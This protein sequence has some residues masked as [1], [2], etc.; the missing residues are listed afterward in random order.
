[1]IYAVRIRY[2][3]V[4]FIQLLSRKTILQ[5]EELE[6]KIFGPKQI[7][8]AAN[9]VQQ[10]TFTGSREDEQQGNETFNSGHNTTVRTQ[11][12]EEFEETAL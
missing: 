11:Q 8:V 2:F 3:R 5:A 12:D 7:G 4:A 9:V 1:M 6:R 10:E